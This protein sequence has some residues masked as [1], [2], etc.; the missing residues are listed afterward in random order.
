MSAINLQRCGLLINGHAKVPAIR[1]LI[2]DSGVLRLRWIREWFD[3]VETCPRGGRN[4][5]KTLLIAAIW[6]H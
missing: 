3:D 6:K 5:D 4:S 1:L 2:P